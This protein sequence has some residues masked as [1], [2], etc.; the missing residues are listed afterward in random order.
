MRAHSSCVCTMHMSTASFII[1]PR[2]VACRVVRR[3]SAPIRISAA[4]ISR[5]AILHTRST[6]RRNASTQALP[7]IRAKIGQAGQ[8]GS[9]RTG[10]ARGVGGRG[11]LGANF[12]LGLGAGR[13]SAPPS[14]HANP[15]THWML[16]ICCNILESACLC[17]KTL[18]AACNAACLQLSI[19]GCLLA[20]MAPGTASSGASSGLS[21]AKGAPA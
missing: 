5:H 1:P 21:A 19:K 6:R 8:P 4:R 2:V 10:E 15:A 13:W 18:E 17:C 16:L 14:A 11:A 12:A 20:A 7:Q 3:S 9:R